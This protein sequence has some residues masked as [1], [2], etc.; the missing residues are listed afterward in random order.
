[1]STFNLGLILL[2]FPV[3]KKD[4]VQTFLIFC[5]CGVLC[6]LRA[7]LHWTLQRAFWTQAAMVQ[8]HLTLSED[9][10][11]YSNTVIN[12]ESWWWGIKWEKFSTY[13]KL[14]KFSLN[15]ISKRLLFQWW[16]KVTF[17]FRLMRL[18]TFMNNFFHHHTYITKTECNKLTMGCKC[19]SFLPLSHEESL[20]CEV[21]CSSVQ[22]RPWYSWPSD[23]SDQTECSQSGLECE[24][25]FTSE[26]TVR[27]GGKL[28]KNETL[29]I[30]V[31]ADWPAVFFFAYI[32]AV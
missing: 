14:K 29:M 12:W 8:L 23:R 1:M 4:Y 27:M 18:K 30:S 28:K 15:S 31:K 11:P 7:A 20:P 16:P 24:P 10:C 2:L 26:M 17:T 22:T 5:H 13:W 25:G 9:I 21:R 6:R 3:M 19:C 32:A